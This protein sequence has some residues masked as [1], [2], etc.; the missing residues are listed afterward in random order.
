MDHR[1]DLLRTN[2]GTV[3]RRNGKLLRVPSPSTSPPSAHVTS[4]PNSTTWHLK[5]DAC[6]SPRDTANQHHYRLDIHQTN[7]P[8]VTKSGRVSKPPQRLKL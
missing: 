7:A 3:V 2:S 4:Q 8:Y 6:T 5:E 1:D